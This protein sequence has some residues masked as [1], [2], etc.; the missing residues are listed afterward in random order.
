[1][2]VK[3][4]RRYL[5]ALTEIQNESKHKGEQIFFSL[6]SGVRNSISGNV[7]QFYIYSSN[8]NT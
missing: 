5:V 2:D 4:L 7:M 6:V 1:M 8:K 3:M